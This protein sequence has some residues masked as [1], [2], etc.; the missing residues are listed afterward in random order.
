MAMASKPGGAVSGTFPS[1]KLGRL[2]VYASS[3]ERDFLFFA[4]FDRDILHYQEQ[5]FCLTGELPDGSMHRYTPDFL[6]HRAGEQQL[7]ECKPAD[8]LDHPHTQQQC[9]LGEAWAAEHDCTFR[10]VTD[11]ELR[12]GHVLANLKLLWRYSRWP[13]DAH[14]AATCLALVQ[15]QPE[16]TLAQ[17]AALHQPD[18]PYQAMPLIYALLSHHRLRADLTQV[19]TP[20]SRV[21]VE[22]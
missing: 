15:A 13:L 2:V 17:L 1:L 18:Q 20:D 19:L 7:V 6:V 22:T 8:A 5:P 11:E 12:V 3:V 21:S 14:A 9:A 16:L 4:E 10:L